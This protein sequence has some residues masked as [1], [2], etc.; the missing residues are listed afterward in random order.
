MR[1]TVTALFRVGTNCHPP[2]VNGLSIKEV[3]NECANGKL[4]QRLVRI[5][6]L[7]VW[8]AVPAHFFYL[9]YKTSCSEIPDN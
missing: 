2:T 6:Q 8:D 7:R 9:A 4:F 1:G 3:S 5:Q